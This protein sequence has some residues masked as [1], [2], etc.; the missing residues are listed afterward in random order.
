MAAFAA[1][2]AGLRCV[3]LEE[4]AFRLEVAIIAV[5]LPVALFAEITAGQKALLIA[6]LLLVLVAELINSAIEAAVDWTA[7]QLPPESRRHPLAAKAKDAASAGVFISVII[8]AV[9][10]L[11]VFFG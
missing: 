10:W 1:S 3:F 2:V 7:Q 5:L 9:V 8:A 4:A 6:V 11:L